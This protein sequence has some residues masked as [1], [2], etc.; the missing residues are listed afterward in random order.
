M[1][2]CDEIIEFI[3]KIINRANNSNRK[4]IIENVNTFVNYLKL[5]KSLS[6][7]DLKK[8]D[9]IVDCID[10]LINLK[11]KMNLSKIDI[12][13]IIS[14]EK[15]ITSNPKIITKSYPNYEEK[16]YIH[17]DTDYT[18]SCGG[19]YRYRSGC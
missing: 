18:S 12:E 16:H 19:G 5:T 4:E 11:I 8:V 14:E 13:S 6:T 9:K 15:E 10:E 1:F 2:D 7:K 3:N 17:Y